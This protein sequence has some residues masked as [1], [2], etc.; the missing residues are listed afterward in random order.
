MLMQGQQ[1][2]MCYMGIEHSKNALKKNYGLHCEPQLK[3]CWTNTGMGGHTKFSFPST[4]P[5]RVCSARQLVM[6]FKRRRRANTA[7]ASAMPANPAMPKF[8]TS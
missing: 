5:L 1:V 3:F 8:L 4:S 7:I 2:E 6:T